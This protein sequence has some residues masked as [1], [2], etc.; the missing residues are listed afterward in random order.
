MT[1]PGPH[2]ALGTSHRTRHP[3]RRTRHGAFS[4]WLP[5]CALRWRRP[6]ACPPRRPS[7]TYGTDALGSVRVVFDQSGGVIA[8]A[9]YLPFGEEVFAPGPMPAERFT[10]QTRDG[11]AGLDYLHARTFSP[12]LGRFTAVDPVAPSLGAPQQWNRYTYVTNSPM[13]F[14][15]P[16]GLDP[17]SL[18]QCSFVNFASVAVDMHSSTGYR[19]SIGTYKNCVDFGQ[20]SNT[21][22]FTGPPT[23]PPGNP[24][25]GGGGGG[26]GNPGGGGDPGGGDPGGGDPGG[27]PGGGGGGGNG[28]GTGG[29]PGVVDWGTPFR[30]WLRCAAAGADR[31]SFASR[32]SV[33]DDSF[34]GQAL[35]GNDVS[36]T[37]WLLV[38]P[39]EGAYTSRR[40][41]FQTALSNGLIGGGLLTLA[42]KGIG[43]ARTGN[44][45][46]VD[47]AR[48]APAR[49]T[50]SGA[51]ACGSVN[52]RLSKAGRSCSAWLQQP[53][54]PMT[55]A[56]LLPRPTK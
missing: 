8:R 44:E 6:V 7:S 19:I 41:F 54:W 12:R 49:S 52:V 32:L 42:G 16:S 39:S 1:A 40:Q 26:G 3:A 14:V 45:L 25:N 55:S 48:T 15:D 38:G 4:A 37:A 22:G 33:P 47:Q 11:E 2:R 35:L 28:G 18:Q 23:G 46:L 31:T 21:P 36:S 30:S 53:S 24:G 29:S 50:P 34:L 5:C 20:S 27:D 51:W 17:S 56:H 9:D 10:G 13:A 43:A